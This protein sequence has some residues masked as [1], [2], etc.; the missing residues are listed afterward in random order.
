MHLRFKHSSSTPAL[1]ALQVGLDRLPAGLA[2]GVAANRLVRAAA[3]QGEDLYGAAP[4]PYGENA[5]Q[6]GALL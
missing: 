3:G 5:L 4:R 2:E 1:R 6:V